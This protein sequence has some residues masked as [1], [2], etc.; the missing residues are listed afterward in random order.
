MLL[1]D[2]FQLPNN[3]TLSPEEAHRLNKE[4]ATTSA[5]EIPDEHRDRVRDYL[6][7][8]LNFNSVSADSQPGMDKLLS[9]L[10]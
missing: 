4:L 6:L 7:A 8:A 5:T 3:H 2:F 10:E 1:N 9:E